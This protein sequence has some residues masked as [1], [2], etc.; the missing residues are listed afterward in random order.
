MQNELIKYKRFINNIKKL[1]ET[2]IK[3]NNKLY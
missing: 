2:I 3:F 1:I